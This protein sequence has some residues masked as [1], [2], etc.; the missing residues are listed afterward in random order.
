GSEPNLGFERSGAPVHFGT[1]ELLSDL[2]TRT[3]GPGGSGRAEVVRGPK[4]DA[5]IA[6]PST[7]SQV[8]NAARVVAGMR[9]GFRACY[10][11]GVTESPEAGGSTRLS[12]EGGAGGE[13]LGVPPVAS[14]NLP[15]S[16]ISCVQARARVAQFDRPEGGSALIQVP[17]TFVKQ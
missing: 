14:G 4:I 13:V 8:S 7:T 6:P 1:G 2:G 3:L 16:V 10:K 9:A 11:R 17:V 15:A 5:T 12:I